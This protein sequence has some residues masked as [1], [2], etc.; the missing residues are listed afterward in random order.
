V[1]FT[2]SRPSSA[3]LAIL[4]AAVLL[5]AAT[6]AP[7]SSE[8]D[9]VELEFVDGGGAV[10]GEIDVASV[11]ESIVKVRQGL[12]LMTIDGDCSD[13]LLDE[14]QNMIDDPLI[15]DRSRHCSVFSA[16]GG[17]SV[18]MGRNWDNENVGSIVATLYRPVDGYESVF[19]FR[20]IELGFGKDID[21]AVIES[22]AIGARFL[23][24]PY[25]SMD[26]VNEHGLAVAVAGDQTTEVRPL[27]GKEL[28]GISFV[29]RK[30]LDQ[31]RTVD[32]AVELVQGY[33][34]S[35]LDKNTM[36][37]HLM[38]ADASGASAVLEYDND[39]WLVTRGEG[40]WQAM[41]TKRIHDVSVETLRENCWR[42]DGMSET[43][44]KANGDLD[45]QGCMALLEDLTQKGTTWSVAYDLGAGELHLSVYQD[46]D[47]V[48]HLAAP[49]AP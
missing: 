21:L 17:G 44:G 33:V 46:W 4:V 42:Y 15:N 38:V 24:A 19:F 2:A 39:Q 29:I 8:S 31:T 18:L 40:T 48:Y 12:Y 11:L 49:W 1:P 43:L 20:S 13:L 25:Y 37:G 41:S 6:A 23:R 9:V 28:V 7:A 27:P 45:W 34:P 32:E 14:N 22:H 3:V 10:D 36:A 26:G 30:L 5:A 16:S 35:L 47:T